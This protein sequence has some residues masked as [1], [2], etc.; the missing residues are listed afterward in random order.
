MQK[1][2]ISRSRLVSRFAGALAIACAAMPPAM[3]AN[4]ASNQTT[5][6]TLANW[7]VVR[8]E[9]TMD[10]EAKCT[11]YYRKKGELQVGKNGLYVP[12]TGGLRSI[13]WRFGDNTAYPLRLP[14]E[15]EDRMNIA[16]ITDEEFL[17]VVEKV[18]V[19]GEFM[20]R[21]KGIV[22]VDY[23]ITGIKTVL[24]TIKAGCPIPEKAAKAKKQ[25]G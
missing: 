8:T 23:D 5:V 18:R 3:P 20:T 24:A 9:N 21:E 22:Q 1:Q 15:L 4:A 13:Q 14:L 25:P 11:G 19:R 17:D 2:Y 10:D 16:F 6:L 7:Q 12:V